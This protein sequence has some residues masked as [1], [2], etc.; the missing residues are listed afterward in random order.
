MSCL[1]N[2][3]TQWPLL[4]LVCKLCICESA[5]GS[6]KHLLYLTSIEVN[7]K[8]WT[9]KTIFLNLLFNFF[10]ENGKMWIYVSND[11]LCGYNRVCPQLVIQ[12]TNKLWLHSLSKCLKVI[13]KLTTCFTIQIQFTRNSGGFFFTLSCCLHDL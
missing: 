13:F 7:R 1:L 9:F 5:D 2:N 8:N 11:G 12:F 10:N 3:K 4:E 6:S